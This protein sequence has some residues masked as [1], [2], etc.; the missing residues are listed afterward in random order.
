M[1]KPIFFTV[2]VVV[3]ANYASHVNGH[4]AMV[5]PI[6]WFDKKQWVQTSQGMKFDYIGMKIGKHCYMGCK[7]SSAKLCPGRKD[8]CDNFVAPGCSCMW[9]NN[10]TFVQKP[11]LFDERLRTYA[12]SEV[13]NFTLHHPWRAPG[14]APLDSP[15][16]VAGGNING[17]NGT[18]ILGGYNRGPKA[19]DF[20]FDHDFK[21]TNWT[22][23][24]I[25]EVAWGV[26]ANHGGGYSY[27]LCKVP[28]EGMHALT[29]ECFQQ[30][31]L[32]FY[33]DS[34]WIQYGEDVTTRKEFQAVRTDAGT[35][36]KGSQWTKNPIP[37][38]TGA[39]GG[40]LEKTK[41]INGTQF[42]PPVP[43]EFGFGTN[44]YRTVKPFEF[45]IID[46][47]EIPKSL[48]SG[49]YVVSFRWDCEQS[50]QVWNTC[51]SVALE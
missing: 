6:N 46:K 37:A 12:R 43:S 41:C 10:N 38:C 5:Q 50:P 30:T 25:V 31:P 36:P 2:C 51:S 34:Q 17:C 21:V 48:E 18:C 47:V 40:F 20:E 8:Y 39:F 27:R 49:N 3:F 9:F 26:S 35:T 42:P 13:P 44:V 15:C 1:H 14:A 11:T 28:A 29:E 23:G 16:G 19:E 24:S 33:G 4:G 32:K 7:I 45:V 22:R